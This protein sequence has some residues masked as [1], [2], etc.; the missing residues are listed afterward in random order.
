MDTT[1]KEGFVINHSLPRFPII[2]NGYILINYS[3]EIVLEFDE[4]AG[5]NGQQ[6]FC[7]SASADTIEVMAVQYTVA[8]I[9]TSAT[10]MPDSV[11]AQY[12]FIYGLKDNKRSDKDLQSLAIE[13][14]KL[15]PNTL[16][17]KVDIKSS[18]S[19]AISMLAKSQDYE[20][21]FYT[22]VVAPLLKTHLW[23]ETWGNGVGGLMDPDCSLSY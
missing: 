20:Q 13:K 11:A 10:K 8:E 3:R 17:G 18:G 14:R 21:D 23:T 7:V 22:A 15:I 5:V 4:N 9:R 2:R 19:L 12:P 1:T 16:Y 6:F